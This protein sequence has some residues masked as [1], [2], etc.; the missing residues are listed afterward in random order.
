MD[1]F[2]LINRFFRRQ[3]NGDGVEI[4]VGDDAAVLN[5]TPGQQLVMSL[6]T[7]LEGRHFPADMPARDLGWRSLAVNL[8]DLAAMGAEPRWSLGLPGLLN[9]S[10]AV[11]SRAGLC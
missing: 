8:S 7:L 3:P 10:H 2:Q 6:D 9:L 11:M 5:P 1:E 4:S